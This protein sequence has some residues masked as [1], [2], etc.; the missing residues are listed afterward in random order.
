M[1]SPRERHRPADEPGVAALRDEGHAVPAGGQHDRSDLWASSRPAAPPG[2]RPR[3]RPV[4]STA[5]P[6]VRSG[7]VMTRSAPRMATQSSR[8]ARSPAITRQSTARRPHTPPPEVRADA[9]GVGPMPQDTSYAAGWS[10]SPTA[11][12]AILEGPNLAH[13]VTIDPD[14]APQ[15][16]CVWVGV[17]G[18]E[19]V[20]A[21]ARPV[22]QA[23][24]PRARPAH[25][26]VDRVERGQRHGDA[27]VPRAPGHRPRRGRARAPELLQELAYVYIGPD[28][29]FPP[30]DDPPPGS[31]VRITVDR[32]GGVGPWI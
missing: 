26:A 4:Q 12:R 8:N 29:R 7:S 23:A 1:T 15:V 28:V 22:A 24:Q 9:T 16:S 18:D 6:A 3:H 21:L 31:V 11:A 27:G 30:M 20:F 5:W 32:I 14:G 19:V 13:V 17:D 2:V 10:Q 25:R